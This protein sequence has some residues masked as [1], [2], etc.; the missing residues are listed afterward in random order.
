MTTT[1]SI[2]ERI[3]TGTGIQIIITVLLFISSVKVETR[4]ITLHTLLVQQTGNV[5]SSAEKSYEIK[6]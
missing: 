1:S 2:M 3:I 4:I 6:Y 5:P